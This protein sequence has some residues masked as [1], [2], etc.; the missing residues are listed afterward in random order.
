MTDT[1]SIPGAEVP[2]G[3]ALEQARGVD[4]LKQ[5]QRKRQERSASLFLP[6][7]SWDELVVGEYRIVD[8][9]KWQ[10]I[11]E[12]VARRAN[13]GSREGLSNDIELILAACVGLHAVDPESGNRVPIEDDYG[14]V[15]YDRIAHVLGVADEIESAS[16]AV[17]YMMAERDE[18]TGKWK[19]NIIA[20]GM[21]AQSISRWMRDP[22]KRG[23]D[24]EAL[25]G[26][27]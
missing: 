10:E 1:G 27:L 21:H 26:E 3:D 5:A 23:V 16:D 4:L 25:L 13:N 18:E 7:P 9:P 17:R 22:S 8:K 6:I 11:A 20:I 19:E 12:R 15:K 24:L 14:I 2:T